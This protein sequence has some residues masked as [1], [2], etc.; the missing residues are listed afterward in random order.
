MLYYKGDLL[1]QFKNKL[2]VGWHGYQKNGHRV[3]AYPVN[4][5]GEPT[6]NQYEEIVFGWDSLEGIRP[7]GA[8]TGLTEL[9]DGSVL[10]LDDKNGALLRLSKGTNAGEIKSV[11]EE[12]FSEESVK[13]FL[14]LVPFVK[15]NCS[16]CH[17][18]FQ[19]ETAIEILSGMKGSMLNTSKATESSFYIK[20][21]SKQMP[22]EMI[23]PSLE[24]DEEQ[25]SEVMIQIDKFIRTL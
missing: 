16:M 9:N 14:P 8:P 21:K 17:A 11:K 19:K 3:V 10:I 22:P 18:E 4:T 25:F 13:A 2:L 6:S 5:K 1:P 20:L 7:R 23:R 24:F 15:K 12:Q